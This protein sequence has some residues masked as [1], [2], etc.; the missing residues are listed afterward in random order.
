MNQSYPLTKETEAK[1]GKKYTVCSV[2]PEPYK[3][4]KRSQFVGLC[5]V[6]WLGFFSCFSLNAQLSGYY[7]INPSSAA[8][9]TNYQSFESAV[10]DLM[11]GTRADGGPVGG[12][13]VSGT[14]IFDVASGTYTLSTT[15]VIRS[16]AGTSPAR[17][18]IFRSAT[19]VAANVTLQ[20][21]SPSTALDAVIRIKGADN[22]MFERMTI[23][24]NSTNTSFSKGFHIDTAGTLSNTSD[25]II[26]RGCVL[27]TV[28]HLGS[29]VAVVNSVNNNRNLRVVGCNV[30]KTSGIFFQGRST[31]PYPAGLVIDSNS[32]VTSGGE[33]FK[34]VY[35]NYAQAPMI[36]YNNI[37]KS[38]CCAD[39][40]MEIINVKGSMVIAYN[41][42]QTTAGHNGVL[43]SNVNTASTDN[44]KVKIFNNTIATAGGSSNYGIR[45][46]NTRFVDV[47]H[48]N[49][50]LSGA[51]PNSSRAIEIYSDLSIGTKVSVSNNIFFANGGFA[52][53][54]SGNS[55]ANA[56]AVI[57][58][59]DF[60]NYFNN[61]SST[62]FHFQG[63]GYFTLAAFRNAVYATSGGNDGNSMAKNPGF[64]STSNLRVSAINCLVGRTGLVAMDLDGALRPAKCMMG[65]F[66]P[67]RLS[68]NI[69]V[70][71]FVSPS[72]P[73]SL[74]SQ[75]IKYAVYNYGNNT[76]S[77]FNASY[78]VN[79]A[80]LQSRTISSALNTCDSMQVTFSG[81]Q[82]YNFGGGYQ[83]VRGFTSNPNG[84]TDAQA[85]NDTAN[86]E[87][88]Q[89]LSGGAYTINPAGSG[90]SNF[91]SFTQAAQSLN[92]CGINGPVVFTV[93]SG[94]YNEQFTLNSISGSSATNFVEFKSAS[95]NPSDV[96]ITN[97]SGST[98]NFTVR[99]NNASWIKFRNLSI[100]ANHVTNGN[101]LYLAN[102]AARDSFFNV[103]FRG[104]TATTDNNNASLFHAGTGL[105]PFIYLIDCR[106]INGSYGIYVKSLNNTSSGLA[107]DRSE[108]FTVLNCTFTNQ[109]AD[110]IFI[111]NVE[112]LRLRNNTISTNSAYS[113]YCGIYMW[114][115]C[116]SLA[117]NQ[118]VIAGNRISGAARGT[119]IYCNFMLGSTTVAAARI[120]VAN[121]FVQIGSGANNAYGIWIDQSRATDY[122]HNSVL[123]T[124]TQ[125]AS[126][127]AAFYSGNGNTTSSYN[128]NVCLNNVF[129]SNTGAPAVVVLDMPR[130]TTFNYNNIHTT[131]TNLAYLG[132][133]AY[134]NLANWRTASAV[135]ANSI[136]ADPIFTSNTDLHS[137]QTLMNNAGQVTALV[138][139]DYDG[140]S[141]CPNGGCPGT[142]AN[143]D[144]GA[145]EFIPLT[146]D[147]S[148]SAITAPATVCPNTASIIVVS[149]R[150]LGTSS[151]TSATLGWSV[152]GVAQTPF[153]WTGTLAQSGT[154]TGITVGSFNFT[155]ASNTIRVWSYNPNGGTDE[156]NLNDTATATPASFMAGLYTI[157]GTSPAYPDFTSAVA[158]LHSRGIC[159]RVTFYVRQGTYTERIQIN[160]ITGSSVS[161]TIHFVP[162]PANTAAV[163][164]TTSGNTVSSNYTINLNGTRFIQF[165][166]L[167]ITNTSSGTGTYGSVITL[168]G[169]QDSVKFAQ[170]TISGPATTS[171]STNFAVI[172]SPG[173]ASATELIQRFYL[174]SCTLSGG[175]VVVFTAGHSTLANYEFRTRIRGNSITGFHSQGISMQ[176]AR[177]AW[178]LNNT[179]TSTGANNSAIGI[180]MMNI[181][182]FRIESNRI[183]NIGNY[184]IYLISGNIQNSTGS[185]KATIINN[186]IGGVGGT[187][188][189]G[190]YLNPPCRQLNVFHNSVSVN[191][192]NYAIFL[193][194]TSA[195]Q[196][197]N[198]DIRNNS[199]ANFGTGQAAYFYNSPAIT[200]LSIN[201][202]NYFSGGTT[203]YTLAT[204]GYTVANGG[205]P[206]FNANSRLGN[207][208]YVNNAS[209]LR[210]QSVQ[211]DG[212]GIY[213]S[214][215]ST[216]IDGHTR[217]G[218]GG[219][220]DIGADE[221]TVSALSGTYTIGGTTP[222]YATFTDAATALAMFGVSGRV[223]FLVR[224]GTYNERIQI[225]SVTG[226]SAANSITFSPDPANTAAAILTTT[227]N[228]A[229]TNNYTLALNGARFIRFRG[230]TITNTSSGAGSWGSV[231]AL[232]G[233]QD[234]IVFAQ[235]TITGPTTSS[236]STNFAVFNSASAGVATDLLHRLCID[237]NTIIGGSDALYLVG[238]S[239]L[240]NYESRAR[241]RGNTITGFHRYGVN[242]QFARNPWILGNTI[243][244]SGANTSAA[245]LYLLNTDTFRI[246]RNILNNTGVY[247]IYLSYANHQNNTG[248]AVSTIINNMVGGTSSNTGAHG[249]YIDNFSRFIN[250]YHNSVSL[251][252]SG[253]GF[254]ISQ[255]TAGRYVNLDI[256]NNSFANFGSGQAAYFYYTT[257]ITNLTI[258]YNNYHT[259]GTTA[260]TIGTT[261]YN[262]ATGGAPT[263]N[264]NSRLGNP[265]YVNNNNDLHGRSVQLDNAGIYLSSV[266]TDMD[267]HTRSG[268]GGASDMGADEYAVAMTLS[269]VYTIGGTAPDFATFTD[270]ATALALYGVA[271]R[272]TFRVREGTYNE[273]IQI[274]SIIGNTASRG[275]A[276]VPDP[277]NTAAAILTTTGNAAATNY[278]LSLNGTSFILFRGLTITNT[279][280]GTSS[281][282]S[283]IALTGMQDSVVFAQN[284]ITGPSTTNTSATNFA[285]LNSVSSSGSAADL[286]HRLYIDSNTISGGSDAVYLIGHN[287][288]T[289]YENRARIRGN[290][291]TGFHRYGVNIQFARNTWILGNTVSSTGANTGASG[292]YVRNIDTFRI[293]RN[294]INNIGV[295]GMYLWYANHQ[296]NTGTALSTIINNMVGGNSASTGANGIYLDQYSR[297]INIYHNSVSLS[298]SG[299]GFY[300][301]QS[302]SGM[303]TNLD[304]RNNSFANFGTGQ[305]AY[306]YYSSSV[307]NLTINY[308]NHHSAASTKFTLGS[309]GHTTA[310]GGA[311]TFNANSKL[312]D[313]VY[314]SNSNNLRGLAYQLDGAGIFIASVTTDFDGHTRTGVGGVAD[315]GADEYNVASLSGTYTI[316]GT[317]P[318][319]STFT[320]ASNALSMFGVSGRVDF[321]VREGTYNERIQINNVIGSSAANIITFRPDPANTAP[322]ILTTSGNSSSANNYTLNLNGT[323]F[324]RFRGLTITNTS[325]GTGSFGSV[326]NFSGMQDSVVF[327]QN[328][329]TGP[330]TTSTSTNFAVFNSSNSTSAS[331]LIHR[332]C[333][334]SNTISGGSDAIYLSGNSAAPNR[335]SATRIR[336]NSITGF[337]NYGVN[338]QYSRNTWIL[339]NTISSTGANAS[340][341]G[342][343]LQYFD[344][345]RI[346][347]NIINNIGS[348]GINLSYANY[349]NNTGTAVSTIVNNMVGG[350]AA[351]AGANGI[352]LNTY[353]RYINIYHNSVSVTGTGYGFYFNQG[354][355]DRYANLDIRNNSFA[356]FGT[357]Q[358][359]Y[360]YYASSFPIANLTINYNNYFTAGTTAFTLGSSSFNTGTG[361]APFNANSRL[362]NPGYISNTSNL[363]SVSQQLSDGGVN[364][365]NVTIDIDGNPRPLNVGG[366]VDIGAD[367]YDVPTLNM[368]VTAIT[369]PSCPLVAGLQNVVVT[370]RNFGVATVTSAI[371]KYKVGFAGAVRTFNWSGSL[372]T[373]A[374]ASVTFN[375]ANQYNF[376]KTQIDSIIAWTEM[377][378]G[379]GDQFA[380][381]DS[382]IAVTYT[383]LSGTY[384]IGGANPSFR[385]I[386]QAVAALNCEGVTGPVVFRIRNGTYTESVVLNTIPGSSSTNTITFIS[387]SGSAAGT[388]WQAMPPTAYTV[389]MNNTK[390]VTF[391]NMTV[392]NTNNPGV[393]FQLNSTG[394][395]SCFRI[396]VQGCSM[397]NSWTGATNSAVNA[398]GRAH[399]LRILKNIISSSN[400]LNI[401]GNS[402]VSHYNRNLVIDS[403]SIN[404][405]IGDVYQPIVVQYANAPAIRNNTITRGA[406]GGVLTVQI[407]N[408]FGAMNFVNNNIHSGGVQGIY[409]TSI[410]TGAGQTTPAVIANNFIANNN[411]GAAS[412]ALLVEN[413]NYLHIYNN[414]IYQNSNGAAASALRT[415]S[416]GTFSNVRFVNNSIVSNKSTTASI[417]WIAAGT[418]TNIRAM[419]AE[420]NNNNY[421][422]IGGSGDPLVQLAGANYTSVAGLQGQ[423]YTAPSNNDL[424]SI[425]VNPGY[426]SVSGPANN[427]RITASSPLLGTGRV[428]ASI[429]RDI[430][431]QARN[432][433]Y[434]IGADQMDG[435]VRPNVG[436]FEA[437]NYLSGSAWI[438]LRD[439]LGNLV[440]SINPN[441]NNL[442]STCWGIR[443]L[444]STN[445]VTRTYTNPGKTGVN[446]LWLD[447]NGYINPANQPTTPVSIRY[448]LLNTELG[449]VR[450][451]A[452]TLGFNSEL[453][454]S[455]FLR[456]SM[457]IT[458]TDGPVSNLDPADA[459]HTA[460][461][462]GI[463]FGS[464]TPYRSNAVYVQFNV[465]SFS[466]FTPTYNPGFVLTPL[467]L[468]SVKLEATKSNTD[469]LLKWTANDV[470]NVLHFDLE[471]SLG[472]GH[473]IRVHRH[474]VNQN[475]PVKAFGYIDSGVFMNFDGVAYYR[476]KAVTHTG[477][478]FSELRKVAGNSVSKISIYPNPCS[479][480]IFIAL[481]AK[482]CGTINKVSVVDMAGRT[483][484]FRINKV[485]G[486]LMELVFDDYVEPGV[487]FVRLK[488]DSDF[489]TF[490]IIKN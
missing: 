478:L 104:L 400:G 475:S 270:A 361:G 229:S 384:T 476:I 121:N 161:N 417:P 349:Q 213:L 435:Q 257:A 209:D 343:Y 308:N 51:A 28:W 181:D 358:A 63:T 288:L 396:T 231:I 371:V 275:V 320:A 457:I 436:D 420:C 264:A 174:D 180:N 306:Y 188:A 271:G 64:T 94:T 425:S 276:F 228:S 406:S 110:G 149:L 390:F 29:S 364:L 165:R 309:S 462:D 474:T 10:S 120:L 54:L 450:R 184:G 105:N 70:E 210:G 125:T 133:T 211:L 444:N 273:R 169:M 378:N 386:G 424:N 193:Q 86:L 217:S 488:C 20:Y 430:D 27:R 414:S 75:N 22:L 151:L 426:V 277:A 147:A 162:D 387:E 269:G 136:S 311:P 112:G 429:T 467:P 206:T 461:K 302:S 335:E 487:Y 178:I 49:I 353:S 197:D 8:S 91:T 464:I 473:F 194:Q 445:G 195:N 16:I 268:S 416:T 150:N 61:S 201:Y 250:I 221:Y 41:T 40:L 139:T 437:C 317:T 106:F 48:N 279:S 238:H 362:G 185:F 32:F 118:P 93:S 128:G 214:S 76:V 286:I 422:V 419:I 245:T 347:R 205:S 484:G 470:S 232:T 192:T 283:V 452:T 328:T 355:A 65:A 446:G 375:G 258:N 341:S 431:N 262:S 348:N 212:G 198:I 389:Q 367:E 107:T 480:N 295:Y 98:N 399:Q 253:H 408:V 334:D 43:I 469:V 224:Q 342:L 236:T 346:E 282:G 183:N 289:N 340:A 47:F 67:S 333:I 296:N 451:H 458:K 284:T 167:T 148:V 164:L 138:T 50:Y 144:I 127:S 160:N 140:Q 338:L 327:A 336:G 170:N 428:L 314:V 410:N 62:L 240:S 243:S 366:T 434:D 155:S 30:A 58:T 103:T 369:A 421:F 272:V 69:G 108:N 303:Y 483:A 203:T 57:D 132:V 350:S 485:S 129:S 44:L 33:A 315:I 46:N 225:N 83:L 313:P 489:M 418:L 312:G 19:G 199:F 99:L 256:R 21:T 71:S 383:A 81:A 204:T 172:N 439:T 251:N 171:T 310:T 360:F 130:F 36:R 401:V 124:S 191:N 465:S 37:T 78:I 109:Y 482:L 246:E 248:T 372:A 298:S 35:I 402:T 100:H 359:A 304:I 316:G 234:S 90:P 173:G 332:L 261:T 404:T 113:S 441:G 182:S 186:M 115:I 380:T 146:N 307:S 25:S 242:M 111:Q 84:A 73:F 448:Y 301:S 122:I 472:N 468:E 274:N 395:D 321:L 299:Y 447:R 117:V 459:I 134:S 42:M 226:S 26:I 31:T 101:A 490:R 477:H 177:S 249:I 481:D 14:T 440:F 12:P 427:Q 17:R 365:A 254:W 80:S 18:V 7:T 11:N 87:V 1:K 233:L 163:V 215:V 368:G 196:Y 24:N 143:P 322:A 454:S 433:P 79:G 176:W 34:P 297:F 255:S 281:F 230:L 114:Y 376:T 159:G 463:P 326:V 85:A 352:Y 252:S 293:E 449:D 455:N 423:L 370:I 2:M 381:N 300:F 456:D 319:Y 145:D 237:S 179:I 287:T 247:G 382:A 166:G 142:T 66:E 23:L 135:D 325:S 220:S 466:E 354:A 305:A 405:T 397:N 356:N 438:D 131:G 55:L 330:S 53:H 263:F 415:N 208:Y 56:R 393:S 102:N 207:P 223:N 175:S 278:T 68:N 392:R 290:S 409:I 377:P 260:Y 294:S 388:I 239:T 156:N 187:S 374:T 267:G 15:L 126:T 152:N 154:S 200:N 442:G 324:I 344:T 168:T 337:H 385:T 265:Y 38:G 266:T 9:A 72:V 59:L 5:F 460:S 363:R 235:N 218:A 407:S 123:I 157:G 453:D 471:R 13:G 479:K 190:I 412:Y 339:G 189:T 3:R 88:C 52:L 291:I 96:V 241:I 6:L 82:Q 219:V 285:V 403:N 222:N 77:G 280:S 95:G 373:N 394:S 74:G 323:R 153:S 216:D 391:R 4:V 116:A 292:L 486:E 97:T 329:I 443:V 60:N 119:G 379:A 345:F 351:S 89:P 227:G 331:D 244:S 39:M 137:N 259:A 432:V 398:T 357:G 202:N 158:D 45:L 92:G 141:R 411:A 413:S 318:D